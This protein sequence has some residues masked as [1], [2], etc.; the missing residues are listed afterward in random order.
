MGASFSCDDEYYKVVK[1][2]KTRE[3]ETKM[4]CCF[5]F[6]IIIFVVMYFLVY[7]TELE[8]K[9]YRLQNPTKHILK[10]DKQ[11]LNRQAPALLN[12]SEEL[13]EL[14]ICP[15]TLEVMYDPWI[16]TEGNTYEYAAIIDHLSR[17]KTSPITRNPM[18]PT[19]LYLRPNRPIRDIIQLYTKPAKL[20]SAL[21]QN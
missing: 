19:D 11:A 4:G 12:I 8:K 6:V 16:D 15:I 5:F 21:T 7:I 3:L 17:S 20:P 18:Y 10:Q 9:I 2:L 13:E 1:E 14:L